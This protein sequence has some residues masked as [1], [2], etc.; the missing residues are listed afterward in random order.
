MAIRRAQPIP[1]PV[2]KE[3]VKEVIIEKPNKAKQVQITWDD[4]EIDDYFLEAI[5]DDAIA[6]GAGWSILPKF[7]AV[8]INDYRKQKSVPKS[9][10]RSRVTEEMCKYLQ[11][12]ANDA[13]KNKSL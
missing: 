2:I 9:G 13:R 11:E 3:V 12:V 5:W 1:E 8:Q 7:I 10:N 6:C 4:I